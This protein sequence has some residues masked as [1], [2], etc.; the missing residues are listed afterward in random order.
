MDAWR[1][2]QGGNEHSQFGF[3][4]ADRGRQSRGHHN[5]PSATGGREETGLE[6]VPIHVALELSP[7]Q[8]KGLRIMDNRSHEESEWDLALLAPEIGELRDLAFDLSLTGLNGREIDNLLRDPNADE[9][10]DQ[11]PPL[12]DVATAQPGDLWLCGSHRVLC[13]DSTNAE[14]VARLLRRPQTNLDGDRSA[15]RHLTGFRMA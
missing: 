5:R 10:A 12:P 4:T 1:H 15:L 13:G 14:M 7:E 11:I 9:K 6:E 8:V 2:R 3:L